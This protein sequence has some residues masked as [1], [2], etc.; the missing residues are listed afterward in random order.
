MIKINQVVRQTIL[1]DIM[2]YKKNSIKYL[3]Q[4]KGGGQKFFFAKRLD[5]VQ[6]PL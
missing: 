1:S 2:I 3:K 6:K 5:T 4:H